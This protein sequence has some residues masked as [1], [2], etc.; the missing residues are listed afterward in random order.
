MAR[1]KA[2]YDKSVIIDKAFEIVQSQGVEALT[3]RNIAKALGVSPMT[4]YNYVKNIREIEKEIIIKG[5]NILYRNVFE[6]L[7]ANKDKM[8]TSG[9]ETMC[10]LMA[11]NMIDFAQNYEG[12]YL[13]MYYLAQADIRKDPEVQPFYN[14][15]KKLTYKIKM[16]A[17]EKKRLKESFYLF[18]L[19]IKGLINDRI[20]T[21][22][23]LERELLFEHTEAAIEKLFGKEK[24]DD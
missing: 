23:K 22:G 6:D 13:M 12:I 1:C 2:I 20:S 19:I 16:D 5:F 18:E 7:V 14:F 15:F 10:L 21:G 4:L 8:K 3:A 11:E 9:I 17:E 24:K